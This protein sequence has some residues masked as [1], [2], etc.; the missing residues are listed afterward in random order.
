MVEDPPPG[1]VEAQRRADRLGFVLSCEPEVGRLLA[2]LAAAVPAGGR[3]LEM[4]T[5]AGV[6]T[7]WL[8]DGLG[9][10]TDVEVLTVERDPQVAAAARA[11]PWPAFV[12]LAE[13]DALAVLGESGAFDL[14]FADAQ[15]GKWEGLG[16][17]VGA[18][19][20]GG[21]LVVDDMRPPRWADDAHERKTAEVHATLLGHP[22]LVSVEL[23]WS[24]GVVVSVRRRPGC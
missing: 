5:G 6:G 24:S 4:G 3:I 14:V 12:R 23:A 22:E 1:V 20:P 9:T 18:L 17:T 19:R 2:V 8:V 11:G 13:G 16:R 21:V 15:G 10:R 7:A